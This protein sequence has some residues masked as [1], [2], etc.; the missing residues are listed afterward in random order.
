MKGNFE[1][2]RLVDISR[3]YYEE[4]LTQAE[5]AK[6]LKISRPAVSKL[7]AEARIRGIVKIE[8]KSPLE[9]NENL[10]QPLLHQFKLD[11]GLIVQTGSGEA[12]LKHRL[13]ISQATQ[14]IEKKLQASSSIGLGWGLETGSVLDEMKSRPQ[15]GQSNGTVCPIIGSA[16][17]DIKWFQTNE[18]ARI[19]SNKTGYSPYYLPAPAFPM[20]NENKQLFEQTD[21]YQVVSSLWNNLDMVLLGI[22]TYPSVPDQA[23]AARFGDK[24]R[25]EGAVGMMATY[26]YDHEGRFIE[27]DNDIVIRIPLNLLMKTRVVLIIG[28]GLEKIQS[29]VG[30]LKTGL[31]T[32]LITDEETALQIMEY[33]V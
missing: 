23:T 5:I 15:N 11:G 25:K 3:L 22:G 14:Y 9:S 27:S 6:K 19:F 18:L 21:E 13:L 17:N 16:P 26:Y 29:I 20:S 33:R 30:A 28:S 24:L 4:G 8:I 2:L 7:L 12:N 1:I 10:L 31:V 32:H